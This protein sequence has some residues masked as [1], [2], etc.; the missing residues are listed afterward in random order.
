[1]SDE[2]ER[3]RALAEKAVEKGGNADY[4]LRDELTPETALTL[5]E[6]LKRRGSQRMNAWLSRL[7]N[8][9]DAS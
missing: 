1:M 5:L 4:D 2:I 7:I 8:E 3:L 6:E 9:R